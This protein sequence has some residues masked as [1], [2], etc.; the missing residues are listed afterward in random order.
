MLFSTFLCLSWSLNAQETKTTPPANDSYAPYSQ[1]DAHN[2][3]GSHPG[4]TQDCGDNYMLPGDV[5]RLGSHS[6]MIL[7]KEDASHI[8]AEHRSGTPPHN[9]QF[10]LKIRL[11]P[12]EMALY[13]KILRDSKTLPAF[14]TIYFNAKGE[15]VDRTFFCLQ[16][17]SKIFG[18]EKKPGDSF[19]KLFPIR[20]SLQKNA[21]HEGAFPIRPSVVPGAFLSLERGDVEIVF[22]R[23]L[24]GYLAQQ[25][26]RQAIKIR[27]QF[28]VPRLGH[29]PLYAREPMETAS[30]RSSYRLTD[31]TIA[32]EGES[33]PKDF[34]LPEAV[35]PKT[36]HTF[37]LL[38][39]IEKNMVLAIHYYDQAPH[40]F[41]VVLKLK[42]SDAEMEMYR[43]AKK[44]TKIPPLF[45]TR[46]VAIDPVPPQNY[47]FCMAHLSR[48]IALG[49]LG[50]RGTV[51]K[52][53][54]LNDYRLGTPMGILE[55][56]SS[57][58]QVLVNRNLNSFMN[59][60]LVAKD[61]LEK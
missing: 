15:E 50:V 55:L 9:Y 57:K 35:V 47:Y 60:V 61:V 40:N 11:D 44:D 8:L 2:H 13:E 53:S 14:T 22:S 19:E 5:A 41:Q 21:D 59:P 51:Y 56:T 39:E 34:Y 37:V 31:G 4:G 58:M 33:C 38:A 3:D 36:I 27:P 26:F 6:F 54:D 29:S 42:L 25:P 46:L 32:K 16:D 7:G 52:D 45:Q 30:K 1:D 24:P 12:D 18:S 28:I 48:S 17:L 49:T 23:Y 20:A 43:S 10:V